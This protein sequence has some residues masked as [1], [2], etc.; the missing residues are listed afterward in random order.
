MVRSSSGRV[1]KNTAILYVRMTVVMLISLIAV[2]VLLK[3]LG[4]ED[5]G[6]YNAIAGVVLLLNSVTGVLSSSIQRFYSFYQGKKDFSILGEVYSSSL[7]IIS[8]FSLLVL[9]ISETV[10]LW[11]VNNRLG[12]PIER[13]TAANWVFQFSVFSFIATL[14]TIPYSAAVVS[15]EDMNIYAIISMLECLLK[16]VI[17]LVLPFILS[18]RLIVYSLLLFL[19][20]LL[21]TFA[22]VIFCKRRYKEL[23]LVRI[24]NKSLYKQI[25]SFSGWTMFGTFANVFNLQGNTIL[26]NVFFGPIVTAARAISLQIASALNA[27]CNSVVMALRPPM[28][29]SYA[30][31]NFQYLLSVFYSSTK[32]I[33][34]SMLMICLPL[35][36]EMPF[37]LR[38][39]LGEVSQDMIDFSRLIVIYSIILSLH[40]PITIIV[41]ATGVI[42]NYFVF[43][44]SFTLLS[45]PL[46]YFLYRLGYS[47]VSAFWIMIIVFTL[48]HVI[49]LIILKKL[50]TEFSMKSYILKF[51]IPASIITLITTLFVGLLHKLLGVIV[52]RFILSII[53]TVCLVSVLL[54]FLGLSSRE[55][56]MVK[57]FITNRV[58]RLKL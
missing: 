7:V 54:Y 33:Y 14:Y 8:L 52:L 11:F 22:Y 23:R 51:I 44:D 29:K 26:I 53:L 4:T 31:N 40:F 9:V 49:R 38:I 55:R 35:I 28:I 48:A 39:W 20:F 3:A 30:E 50:M 15:H 32:F 46:T 1:A 2:R 43:V 12:I 41:Q 19:V 37:I 36:F 21:N 13:L 45:M 18:D 25:L 42:K 17:A 24:R 5:Y 10:G 16:L 6:V 57:N 56:I 34:Y 47:A 27:F 58:N